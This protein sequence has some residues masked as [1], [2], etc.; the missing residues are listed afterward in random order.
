[1]SLE[2]PENTPQTSPN[3]QNHVQT[4]KVLIQTS[5]MRFL[6]RAPQYG[7]AISYRT[8]PETT[9]GII[10]HRSCL[11]QGILRIDKQLP[12][13]P[14]LCSSRMKVWS[15]T[16]YQGYG[17]PQPEPGHLIAIWQNVLFTVCSLNKLHFV[18][19]MSTLSNIFQQTPY[20]TTGF[21]LDFWENVFRQSGKYTFL[22]PA[23]LAPKRCV[24]RT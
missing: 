12:S 23:P 1:M 21:I 16:S 20:L 9:M 19:Q 24:L 3:T 17:R 22:A 10:L 15:L 14:Y 18:T 8:T 4:P 2:S 5:Q 11:S 7:D 13:C 6:L